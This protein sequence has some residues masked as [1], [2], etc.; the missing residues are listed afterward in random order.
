[1]ATKDY[2]QILGIKQ[3]ASAEEIKQAYRKLVKKFH[4]DKNEGDKFFEE[5]F[6]L[7]QESYEVLS[8]KERRLQYDR[9]RGKSHN[10]Q[11]TSSSKKKEP[12]ESR[13]Y[14]IKLTID[15]KELF[16]NEPF[17]LKFTIDSNAIK[18]ID[19]KFEG[20]TMLSDVR[21]VSSNQSTSFSYSLSADKIGELI[22]PKTYIYTDV[23]NYV[24]T[25]TKKITIL[26]GETKKDVSKNPLKKY[27]SRN[28]IIGS[29]ILAVLLA[30]FLKFNSNKVENTITEEKSPI[31]IKQTETILLTAIDNHLEGR[32]KLKSK[33][34]ANAIEFFSKA[35]KI[36]SLYYESYWDRGYCKS[37]MKDYNGAVMD[38]TKA[39]ARCPLEKKDILFSNR[40]DC[41]KKLKNYD[42]T[43]IDYNNAINLNPEKQLH[44]YRRGE[45]KYYELSDYLGAIK[46][47]TQ[48]IKLN[49]TDPRAYFSRGLTYYYIKDYKKSVKDISK[50][51]ELN[52]N[53]GQYWYDRG[54]AKDKLNL[55]KEA[56]GDWYQA[57][58]LGYNVPAYKL[59]KCKE[60]FELKNGDSPYD[61][62][63][64]T[65]DYDKS[66][67]NKIEFKNSQNYDAIVCLVDV[68]TNKTI[69]NEFISAQNNFEMNKV[70]NGTFYLK[71]FFGNEWNPFLIIENTEIQGCFEK[72]LDLSVY[73]AKEDWFIMT[74]TESSKGINY[75]TYEVT[76]YP[77]S[78]GNM[79]GKTIGVKEFFNE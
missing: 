47:L 2:Y 10:K 25:Q 69:R 16:I 45:F 33:D 74:Q 29:L 53:K 49:P 63:F 42:K 62:Y 1:M 40:A 56:C 58:K 64:G 24:T 27:S 19:P 34:Y 36:D 18:I 39:L 14:K 30:L 57:N 68:Q 11:T 35:V 12:E 22:I 77:V 38:Y 37:M 65:G 79:K 72:D 73:N 9:L 43:L 6:K 17:S 7:I 60:I 67:Y 8:S 32:K 75:S 5:Y 50:S 46:D 28:L 3:S 61:K 51:I 66:S 78:N 26:Q 21:K 48:A 13:E 4:P 71:V 41:Y 55:D 15:K 31:G 20:L 54:D 52:P 23:K 44:W 70:P 76:L 59:K